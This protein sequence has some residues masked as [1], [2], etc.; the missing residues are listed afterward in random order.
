MPLDVEEPRGPLWVLGDIFIRKYFV[1][2]D[3]DKNRIGLAKRRK[4]VRN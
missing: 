4:N 1:I 3:R 2:F